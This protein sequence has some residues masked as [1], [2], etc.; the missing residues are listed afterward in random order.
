MSIRDRNEVNGII[1]LTTSVNGISYH[2]IE[3][4]EMNLSKIY[5]RELSKFKLPC[6]LE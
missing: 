5:Y 6:D 2:L 1:N 4:L 3:F